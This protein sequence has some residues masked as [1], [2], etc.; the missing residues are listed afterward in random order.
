MET[1]GRSSFRRALIVTLAWIPVFL[2]FVAF[3]SSSGASIPMGVEVGARFTGTAAVLAFFVFRL[4]AR[5][6]WPDRLQAPFFLKHLAAAAVFSVV[7]A[8]VSI[9]LDHPLQP[10]LALELITSGTAILSQLVLGTWIYGL[11]AGASYAIR[12]RENALEA[13]R[14]AQ[15]AR[16]EAAQAR[17]GALESRLDP[18]FFYNALHTVSALVTRDPPAAQDAVERLGD[19]MRYVLERPPGQD[20]RLE[21]EWRFTMEYLEF[22][23]LRMGDRLQVHEKLEP[24]AAVARVPP[25]IL[26]PLVE[27]AVRHGIG[28]QP[29]GGGIWLEGTLDEGSRVLELV[30]RDDGAGEQPTTSAPDANGS[31]GG[32]SGHRGTGLA[33]LR[34]RLSLRY[35]EKATVDV[36]VEE[37]GV[38]V[39]IRAPFESEPAE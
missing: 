20:V 16:A 11:I 25:L 7:W 26:Q 10:G 37:T 36:G 18:H 9:Y 34:K 4:A 23:K 24:G 39:R 1:T 27:N 12:E 28:R 30:V 17:F 2:F 33:S 13:D 6:P 38:T 31:N 21:E 19:M 32:A 22:A 3:V 14:V 29:E 35:G 15:E 8:S 5:L